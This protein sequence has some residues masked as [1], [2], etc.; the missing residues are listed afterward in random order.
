MAAIKYNDN[1]T[2][3]LRKSLKWISDLSSLHNLLF[4]VAGQIQQCGQNI[5]NNSI[6]QL[7]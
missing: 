3:Y 4:T 1:G 5:P 6:M 7:H 2:Q